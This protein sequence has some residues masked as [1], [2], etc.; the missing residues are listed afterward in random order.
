MIGYIFCFL[1]WLCPRKKHSVE[2][3]DLPWLWI[4]YD[5]G[6]SSY[7]VTDLVNENIQYGD[8]VNIEYLENLTKVNEVK[9]IYL[10]HKLEEKVI[11]SAGLV[12]ND[13]R[14]NN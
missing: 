1:R 10:T 7:S 6:Y 11:D 3:K 13:G 14:K 4:G 2:T 8:L 9:W 5:N 12:I